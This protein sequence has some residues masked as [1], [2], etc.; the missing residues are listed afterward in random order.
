VRILLVEDDEHVAEPLI[1][2]LTYHGHEVQ[3][4]PTAAGAL[5]ADGADLVLL[6]LGLPDLDGVELCRRFRE[7]SDVPIIVATARSEENDRVLGLQAGADDYVVKPFGF[8]ELL[9]RIDA[10]ARRARRAGQRG[11]EPPAAPEG[12]LVVDERTRRATLDGAELSLTRKEFDLLRFLWEDLGAVRTREEIIDN[13]W[14]AHW[15]GSTRTID[16]HIAALR[17]KLGN[18]AWIETVRGVGF[19]L[20]EPES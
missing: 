11:G 12:R 4:V 1:T 20:C 6:D 9:A 14:D 2:W 15:Y 17:L 10:V 8:R 19:R 16:V 7:G 18:P 5:E 13:V 3:H